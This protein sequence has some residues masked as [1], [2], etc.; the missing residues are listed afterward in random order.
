MLTVICGSCAKVQRIVFIGDKES[1]AKT[2]REA[3]FATLRDIK[4]LPIKSNAPDDKSLPT[5]S[6][7][8][9]QEK[10]EFINPVV[11]TPRATTAAGWATVVA[12]TRR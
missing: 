5:I 8:W 11:Y 1:H 12:K 2:P 6:Q 7:T 10:L 3:S 4:L 9:L